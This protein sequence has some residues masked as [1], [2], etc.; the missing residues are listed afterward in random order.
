MWSPNTHDWL[1]TTASRQDLCHDHETAFTCIHTVYSN[2]IRM[3][4]PTFAVT[5]KCSQA[6][7]QFFRTIITLHCAYCSRPSRLHQDVFAWKRKGANSQSRTSNATPWTYLPPDPSFRSPSRS[8]QW[9][10]TWRVTTTCFIPGKITA[11][12]S[13]T[14]RG[15]ALYI[16]SVSTGLLSII[17]TKAII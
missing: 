12:A 14:R 17:Y 2:N 9:T 6:V 1:E 11:I 5:P 8:L 10:F 4:G 16:Y 7:L 13:Q 15:S 3:V